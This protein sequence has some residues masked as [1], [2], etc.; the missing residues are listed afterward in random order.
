MKSFVVPVGS[1]QEAKKILEV[2]ADYDSFQLEN[3]VKGDYS[4][5]GGLN[6]F[7]NGEWVDWADEEG[8]TIDEEGVQLQKASA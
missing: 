1:L 6:V 4:N 5:M 3:N 7:E 2:L 8:R